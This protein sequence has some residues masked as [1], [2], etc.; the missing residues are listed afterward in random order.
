VHYEQ[1]AWCPASFSLSGSDMG[2]LSSLVYIIIS[3]T[4]KR[5]KL[6][7]KKQVESSL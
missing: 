1:T 6:N 5:R 4:V 3:R 2:R 7:L